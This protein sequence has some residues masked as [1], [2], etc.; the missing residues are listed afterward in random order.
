MRPQTREYATSLKRALDESG[1]TAAVITG[2]KSVDE[3]ERLKVHDQFER[4]VVKV[5]ICTDLMNRGIDVPGMKLVINFDLPLD[6]NKTTNLK[7]PRFDTF[8][9]RCGRVGR[10]GTVG[11][12]IHLVTGSFEYRVICDVRRPLPRCMAAAFAGALTHSRLPARSQ[13]TRRFH[14][15]WSVL[16]SKIEEASTLVEGAMDTPVAPPTTGEG[17]LPFLEASAAAS[18]SG[19]AAGGGGAGASATPAAA[20]GSGGK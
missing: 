3:K 17:S 16:P 19:G 13:L 14:I 12:C 8:Q 1:H 5:L 20:G 9:H 2:D 15:G 11:A 4:G 6:T 7:F 18:A 10:F